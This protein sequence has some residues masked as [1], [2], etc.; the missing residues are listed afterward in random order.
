MAMDKKF[1]LNTVHYI[2]SNNISFIYFIKLICYNRVLEIL[3]YIFYNI[4]I[5]Y[6]SV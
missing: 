2:I 6:S 1:Y 5:N 3:L 4:F